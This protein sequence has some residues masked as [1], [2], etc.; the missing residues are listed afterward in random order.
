MLVNTWFKSFLILSRQIFICAFL[1]AVHVFCFSQLL[2]CHFRAWCFFFFCLVVVFEG[3]SRT[4]LIWGWGSWVV[5]LLIFFCASPNKTSGKLLPP[6]RK[7]CFINQN[8][9]R[10]WFQNFVSVGTLGII[11][12]PTILI[13]NW[14][15]YCIIGLRKRGF[16]AG[17]NEPVV[18]GHHR[19]F[20]SRWAD[21]LFIAR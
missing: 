16:A 5:S 4:L 14:G 10:Y 13:F 8:S 17:Q 11:Q 18:K 3:S 9:R 12:V 7:K 1:V 2:Q 15:H 19:R 20:Q 21:T 6:I